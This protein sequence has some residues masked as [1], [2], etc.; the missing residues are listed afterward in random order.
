MIN[1]AELNEQDFEK[2]ATE[3]QSVSDTNS[4]KQLFELLGTAL[5]I[6][7]YT[8]A[9]SNSFDIIKPKMYD[10]KIEKFSILKSI[11]Y[12]TAKSALSKKEAEEE[13]KSFWL[14]FKDK[15]KIAICN[16]P[17]IKELM[18]G[19]GKLKDYLIVGI[20]LVL[21]ALG[22]AVLNPILLA[23]VATVFALIVKVGF[24]AYCEI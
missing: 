9:N 1:L 17:K 14:R 24:D 7:G 18:T 11:H 12:Y 13:G 3:I 19:Q 5:H 6:S 23:I 10:E 2:M 15:L 22:V 21:A 16:D 20:P 8:V 4:E